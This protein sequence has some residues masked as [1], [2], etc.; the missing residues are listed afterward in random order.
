MRCVR[1]GGTTC[2]GPNANVNPVFQ[3]DASG[4][5]LRSWGAGMFVSPHKLTVDKNGFLWMADNG[6]HQVFKL[7]QDGKVLMTL[8]KKGVAGAGLDEFDAPTEVVI[9]P[10]ATSSSATATPGAAR[11]LAMRAS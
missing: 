6:G 1:S 5:L 3:F 9:A 8:G 7:T 10:M 11:P 4:K 2:A